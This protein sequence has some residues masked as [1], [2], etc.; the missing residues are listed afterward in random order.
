MEEQKKTQ[1]KLETFNLMND[2]FFKAIF[3]SR[4]ARTIITNFLHAIT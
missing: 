4:E 3:R 2:A 1:K